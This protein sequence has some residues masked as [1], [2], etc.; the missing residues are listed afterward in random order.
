MPVPVSRCGSKPSRGNDDDPPQFSFCFSSFSSRGTS[1]AHALR[2]LKRDRPDLAQR[3]LKGEISAHKAA[4]EAGFRR[5]T[6]TAPADPEDLARYLK[7]R[8]T[9]EELSLLLTALRQP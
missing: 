7:R 6:L 4:K 3:V 1:S 2:R 5:P 8:F 9:P